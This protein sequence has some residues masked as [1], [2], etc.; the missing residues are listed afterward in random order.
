MVRGDIGGSVP[1]RR[2]RLPIMV[3]HV[4]RHRGDTVSD[5]AAR[6][7]LREHADLLD[8]R[9][10]IP[11]D[12]T[13]QSVRDDRDGQGGAGVPHWPRPGPPRHGNWP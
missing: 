11:S 10:N 4:R 5:G 13:A 7:A 3:G 9:H 12:D 6:A 8:L 2:V 1:D